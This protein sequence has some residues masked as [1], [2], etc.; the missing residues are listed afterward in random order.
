MDI[1]N[2][3]TEAQKI[4]N[5]LNLTIDISNALALYMLTVTY[6]TYLDSTEHLQTEGKVIE[7]FDSHG[8]PILRP[9]PWVKIQLDSQI[10]LFKLIQEFG[11]SPKSKNK[12]QAAIA[13]DS[14]LSMILNKL[15]ETR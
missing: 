5:D 3:H 6:S 11:F 4:Y 12:I 7:S 9:N 10:Q 2:L 1:S 14:P 8:N 13:D 15:V